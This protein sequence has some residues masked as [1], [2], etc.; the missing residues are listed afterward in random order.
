MCGLVLN[1][2]IISNKIFFNKKVPSYTHYNEI[3]QTDNLQG[4][5]SKDCVNR[6]FSDSP[7]SNGKLLLENNWPILHC[8][9][10]NV[11]L[12]FRAPAIL[13]LLDSYPGSSR[14]FPIT[15]TSPALSCFCQILKMLFWIWRFSPRI[16]S[17]PW[18]VSLSLVN[19]Q[20]CF[21]DRANIYPS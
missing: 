13:L 12:A 5:L 19:L 20:N 1:A 16:N 9:L 8:I 18:L 7:I 17:L 21:L 4:A 15:L 10:E 11:Y 6:D 3:L 2:S 14:Y